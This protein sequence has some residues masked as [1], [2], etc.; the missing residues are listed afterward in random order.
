MNLT[1]G[2]GDDAARQQA[3]GSEP[4]TAASRSSEAEG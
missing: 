1:A 3:G 4:D 2:P